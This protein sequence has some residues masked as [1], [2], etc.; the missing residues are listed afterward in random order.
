MVAANFD[1]LPNGFNFI[2]LPTSNTV[3]IIKKLVFGVF[4][5]S[6]GASLLI[7]KLLKAAG[8]CLSGENVFWMDCFR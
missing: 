2:T 7:M 3:A 1:K 6:Y 5:H 4:E 8:M